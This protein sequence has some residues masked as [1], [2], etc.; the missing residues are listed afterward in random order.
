MAPV[1]ES[2]RQHQY[3]WLQS[4]GCWCGQPA[5]ICTLV[6]LI[7][8][9]VLMLIVVSMFID[10]Y[11]DDDKDDGDDDDE[12]EKPAGVL[13]PDIVDCHCAESRTSSEVHS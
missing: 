4:L 9:V 11:E 5:H 6:I 1:P 7:A 8:I 12:E 13:R 2:Q 3:F 10:D